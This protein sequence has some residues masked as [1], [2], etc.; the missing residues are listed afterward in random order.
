MKLLEKI[1]RTAGFTPSESKIVLFLILTFVAGWGIKLYRNTTSA[2]HKFDYSA[3][4]SEFAARSRLMAPGLAAPLA[5]ESLHAAQRQTATP[6]RK[7]GPGKKININTATAA[8]L[9]RLPG[10]G[11]ATARKIITY[12][13]EHGLFPSVD[14]LLN[15]KGIGKKKLERLRPFCK[16]KE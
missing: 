11:E 5:G 10:V 1:G 14:E 12:R 7:I 4:D 8:E 2:G 3:A 9:A 16:I 15:V 6:V 13:A